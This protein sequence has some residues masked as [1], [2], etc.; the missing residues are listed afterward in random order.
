MQPTPTELDERQHMPIAFLIVVSR[1]GSMLLQTL[2]DRNRAILQWPHT[3]KYFDFLATCDGYPQL[4]GRTVGRRFVEFPG[5]ASLFDS[6][7]SVLLGGR[8]G[9]DMKAVVR[10]DRDEFVEAMASISPGPIGNARRLLIAIHLAM[11]NCLGD[12]SAGARTLLVHVHHGD[13]LWADEVV[14][15][16]NVT[17]PAGFRGVDHLHPDRVIITV[18]DPGDT[19]DSL[20]KF[21]AKATGGAAERELWFERYLRLLIQDWLR[22]ARCER[23]GIP[24]CVVR[25]EDLRRDLKSEIARVCSFL[26]VAPALEDRAVP[27]AYGL[28]WW[29]DIYT[30]PRLEPGAPAPV[31][32]PRWS[33]AEQVYVQLGAGCVSEAFGYPALGRG[34]GTARRAK[35]LAALVVASLWGARRMP[36][37]LRDGRRRLVE[38][39]NFLR[40][41]ARLR[42]APLV[43][44]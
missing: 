6:S 11:R 9:P 17:A 12:D 1:S 32:E 29:G 38:R 26:E 40:A 28:E 33:D 5:H 14:E 25:L 30:S 35:A 21:T 37:G 23:D 16:C 39:V 22:V 8:L 31:A 2:L 41:T 18:R 34:R 10:I 44:G 15:R 43:R 19:I 24:T 36:G 27:T 3:F 20:W 7:E 13:W 42:A 4:D